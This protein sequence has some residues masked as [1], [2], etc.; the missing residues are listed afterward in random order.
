MLLA[1]MLLA[2]AVTAPTAAAEAIDF[3]VCDGHDA[4]QPKKKLKPGEVQPVYRGGAAIGPARGEFPRGFGMGGIAACERALVDPLLDPAFWRRR[5]TLLQG[6]A[7]HELAVGNGKAALATLDEADAV[8]TRNETSPASAAFTLINDLLRARIHYQN[9]ARDQADALLAGIERQR[10][11][12]PGIVRAAGATRLMFATSM[13]ERIDLLRSQAALNPQSLRLLM[14]LALQTG[15]FDDAVSLSSQIS[16][17]LPRQRGGWTLVGG[18]DLPYERIGERAFF[19]GARAYALL[20]TGKQAESAA[21]FAAARA[22]IEAASQPP[23][24]DQRGRISKADKE[25]HARRL[26]AAARATDTLD[27]WGR[28]IALRVKASSMGFSEFDSY[29]DLPRAEGGMVILDLLAQ[30]KTS[31]PAERAGITAAAK[32]I[33]NDF[34]RAFRETMTLS[35]KQLVEMLPV[36]ELDTLKPKMKRQ[37]SPFW[38]GGLNGYHVSGANDPALVNIRFGAEYAT[39][40]LVEEAGL[41]AAADHVATLGKDAFVIESSQIITRTTTVIGYFYTRSTYSA[42]YE[43]RLLV[44]PID[45]AAPEAAALQWRTIKV[46][47]VRNALAA[48]YP[49]TR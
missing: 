9:G 11:F 24:P 10:A 2:C 47:D 16:F 45:S 46:A 32:S 15:R 43:Y 38:S 29:S 20:A 34:D 8:F 48:K 5:A 3:A 12:A 14:I 44:R 31:D 28:A 25:D 35:V 41:L 49:P 19:S 23:E 4:P 40:A 42:G 27:D 7:I 1:G 36:I 13:L 26:A 6:R 18:E 21:A 22:E 33:A 30:L 39:P 17:D 37:S